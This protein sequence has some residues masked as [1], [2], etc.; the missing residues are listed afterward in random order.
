MPLGNKVQSLGTRPSCCLTSR[1]AARF[2][3]RE[4]MGEE[5]EGKVQAMCVSVSLATIN[6]VYI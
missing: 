6:F 5:R 3:G 4:V 1:L 2:E